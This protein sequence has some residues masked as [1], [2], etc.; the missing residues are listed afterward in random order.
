MK[1]VESLRSTLLSLFLFL[2]LG[3]CVNREQPQQNPPRLSPKV[4]MTDVTFRSAALGR[5]MPY[6]IVTPSSISPGQKLP[7]VYLLHGGGGGFRDWTNYS[8]VAKYAESEMIL[9][10]PEGNSSYYTNSAE[11]PEDRYEDYIVHDLISEVE[12]KYALA[13]GRKNRAVAGFPWAGTAR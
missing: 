1:T 11:H 12:N 8:N 3:G 10:M 5:E 2:F 13:T 9:V 6:R 4:V 7:V